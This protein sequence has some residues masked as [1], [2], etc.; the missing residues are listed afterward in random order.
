M[1]ISNIFIIP[2]SDSIGYLFVGF[3]LLPFLTLTYLPFPLFLLLLLHFSSISFLSFFFLFDPAIPLLEIYF[4][5]LLIQM[6]KELYVQGS[7]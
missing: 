6:N 4:N 3:L 1:I 2:D 5:D 7:F